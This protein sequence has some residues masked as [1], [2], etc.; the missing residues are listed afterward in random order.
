MKVIFVVVPAIHFVSTLNTIKNKT[1]NNVIEGFSIT[2]LKDFFT[3]LI[4][5]I[6]PLTNSII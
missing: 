4:N 6:F 1:K 5:T 3:E 2:Q